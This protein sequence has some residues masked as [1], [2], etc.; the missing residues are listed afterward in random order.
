MKVETV[1]R[2]IC[3]NRIVTQQTEKFTI[4]EDA[5]IPD[6][7]PDILKPVSTS[8][9]VCIYKKEVSDGKIKLEGNVDVYLIYL[10]D[11]E[12]D[13]IRGINTNIDF[14]ELIECKDA[15]NGMNANERVTI[16]SIECKVLNGRKVNLKVEMETEITLYANED[17]DIVNNIQN[18][19]DIQEIRRNVKF[20]SVV[21][22]NSTKTYAK[23]TIKIDTG[24]N[25][26]E[27]LRVD[28]N[29][30]NKDSK[31]SYNKILAKADADV[32]IMYLTEDNRI[33]NV[34][35]KIPIMGFVE[36]QNISENDICDTRYTARNIL[37]K[38]NPQEEHSIYVEIE[39]DIACSAIKEEE[40]EVLE[41]LYSPSMNLE[42]SSRNI[43]TMVNKKNKND[44]YEIKE[45][46]QIQE[47]AGETIKDIT[48]MP[49]INNT[50]ISRGKIKYDG[51]VK[52]NFLITSNNQSSV[53]G[54]TKVIPIMYVMDYDEVTE[55]SRIDTNVEIAMQDFVIEDSEVTLNINL[56]FEVSQYNQINMNIIEEVNA[57]DENCSENPYSM[58]IYFVKSGDTLWKI[59]KKYKSTINDIMKLNE[60]EDPDN[61][62]VGMQLFIPK[63]V[64]ARSN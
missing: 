56:N 17:L 11:S 43:A 58:T 35:E 13:N 4:E 14:K 60:I 8:G 49:I 38:P 32:K 9:N 62:S 53:E 15:L 1:K 54:L 47:L 24:D 10:A 61:I 3:I 41:D 25:F 21:G 6:I 26:A 40:I 42:F 36:M 27:I 37:I 63:Y 28:V 31:M 18:V 33:R 29:I 19:K 5:I 20:N 44:V 39:L 50:T 22:S 12:T 2:N 55:N 45:K 64:C 46:I 16:K 30:I 7:K 23:E 57:N 48:I 34:E 52:I 59:A 51:E